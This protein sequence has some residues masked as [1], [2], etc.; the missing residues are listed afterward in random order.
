MA[1][2]VKKDVNPTSGV[3]VVV[4]AFNEESVV[5]EVIH[6]LLG[7]F[8]N[9]ICIDDASSDRT[10]EVALSAGAT[11]LRHVVNLGQGASLQTGIDY[12]LSVGAEIVVTFDS[13]GQHRVEDALRLVERISQGDVDVALGSRFLERGTNFSWQKRAVLRLATAFGNLTSR[14]HLTDAHNGLRA[15]TRDAASRIHIYQNRMAHASEIV[16]QIS[17]LQLRYAEVPVQV[18]YT[19]YSRA[20]GQSVWNSVNILRDLLVR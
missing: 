6:G 1:P 8:A 7:S 13:D 2:L 3:W 15:F 20:K 5:G 10:H 17:Q 4:P 11:V 12:A 14:I 19:D 9:V 16:S 18:L